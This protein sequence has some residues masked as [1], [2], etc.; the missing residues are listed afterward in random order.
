MAPTKGENVKHEAETEFD[1]T[2]KAVSDTL[3]KGK[4]KVG[5]TVAHAAEGAEEILQK[6]KEELTAAATQASERVK[7]AADELKK[8]HSRA[9]A[10]KGAVI[11]DFCLGIPYGIILLLGGFVWFA[12]EKDPTTLLPGVGLGVLQTALS[13]LSFQTWKA[14]QRNTPYILLSLF[15]SSFLAFANGYPYVKGEA[16]FIPTGLVGLISAVMTLFYLYVQG[17]GGNRPPKQD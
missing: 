8:A 17:V 16:D 14:G 2:A 13:Y 9:A 10:K 1:K 15:I 11:H 12:A 5:E 7:G 4:E 6:G 3:Q